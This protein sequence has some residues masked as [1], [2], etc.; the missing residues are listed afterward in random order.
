MKSLIIRVYT[1]LCLHHIWQPIKLF[2]P[3]HQCAKTLHSRGLGKTL[4]LTFDIVKSNVLYGSSI[5]DYVAMEFHR[6]SNRERNRFVTFRRNFIYFFKK[7]YDPAKVDLFDKKEN[8]NPLFRE[9]IKHDWLYSAENSIDEIMM[10]IG[11]HKAVMVKPTDGCEGIGVFKLDGDDKNGVQNLLNDVKLGKRYMIEELIIQHEDMARLNP[12]SVN[13]IRIETVVDS[14]GEPHVTNTIVI[15]G[16]G[17]ACVNNTHHGGIMCHINPASGIIDSFAHDPQGQCLFRHPINEIVLP[18]YQ[19][20]RWDG[21]L[22]FA[23][24]LA[25]VEPSCRYIG[26]DIVITPDGYDIIEGN[27]RPGHCTQ[28]CDGVGRYQ[29][30]KSM[31]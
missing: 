24:R 18:G 29:L 1:A 28:A 7:L 23:K 17:D 25:L 13:T 27:V 5:E 8:F 9:Y 16:A 26:W 2:K 6:K 19:I 11:K 14:N 21:I 22:D 12:S 20:P 3:A 30:I 15:M 10:F 4:P 31:I